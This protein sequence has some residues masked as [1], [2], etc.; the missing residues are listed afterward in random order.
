MKMRTRSLIIDLIVATTLSTRVFGA[1][2]P[3]APLRS[4][5]D[6]S[7]S[8]LGHNVPLDVAAEQALG[9][10]KE[11]DEDATGH[12]IFNSVSEIM[13]LWA[14]TVIVQGSCFPCS[15]LSSFP[16]VAEMYPST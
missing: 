3:L 10:D 8:P 2:L 4:S 16:I 5:G 1:Q 11:P 6:V 12:L 7:P 15:F 9:W 13:Q 14:G